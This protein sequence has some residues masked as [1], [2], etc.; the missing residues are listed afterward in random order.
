ML[1]LY[2]SARAAWPGWKQQLPDPC[3]G[4]LYEHVQ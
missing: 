1:G 2:V 3:S 4:V